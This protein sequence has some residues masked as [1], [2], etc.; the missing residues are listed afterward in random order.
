[1]TTSLESLQHGT[2]FLTDSGIETDLLFNHSVDLPLFAAFPLVDTEAGSGLLSAYFQAHFDVARAHGSGFVFEAPTWRASAHWG[3]QLGYGPNAL[4][5]VNRAAIDLLREVRDGD[6]SPSIPTVV[7]GCIGPQDDGYQPSALMTMDEAAAYHAG[8]VETL[9]GADVDLVCALTMTYPDEAIGVVRA[10]AAA[11]LPSVISFTVETDG[12]LPDGHRLVDAIRVVDDSTD[13]GP[14][15]FGINCAHPTHFRRAVAELADQRSRIGLLRAN[16]ST[17]SHAELDEAEDLDAGDPQ[18]L[19]SEYAELLPML[20][21][22]RV[23]GGCCG[24]DLRHVRA[25]ADACLPGLMA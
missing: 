9:A 6:G 22:L 8:Q 14:L 1:M 15:Y 25:I 12:R 24:T 13:A 16:A 4:A 17:R 20:P 18:E 10:A 5:V 19:A 3:S 2:M 21:G 7:S 23:L 11:D